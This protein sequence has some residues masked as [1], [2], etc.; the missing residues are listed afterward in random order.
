MKIFRASCFNFLPLLK[1]FGC[2]MSCIYMIHYA[3]WY[4]FYN[5]KNV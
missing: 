4:Q 3:I 5:L 1:R 2:K